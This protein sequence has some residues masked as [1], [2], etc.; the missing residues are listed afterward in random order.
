[1]CFYMV[2]LVRPHEISCLVRPHEISPGAVCA[3]RGI[4]LRPSSGSDWCRSGGWR[5]ILGSEGALFGFQVILLFVRLCSASKCQKPNLTPILFSAGLIK[6]NRSVFF[7]HIP[8]GLCAIFGTFLLNIIYLMFI[9]KVRN[10]LYTN[11][12]G[13]RC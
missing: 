7:N 1:M 11:E 6:N 2:S 3:G 13:L 12:L 10:R 8:K 5:R 9:S 4:G